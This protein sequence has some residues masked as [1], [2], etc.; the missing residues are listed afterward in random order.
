MSIHYNK[1]LDKIKIHQFKKNK[2]KI[3]K[4]KEIWEIKKMRE[5]RKIK[6]IW[7]VK[8]IKKIR[9]VKK[10]KKIMNMNLMM[11]C[12]VKMMMMGKM[13]IFLIKT[14]KL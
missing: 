6:K 4:I 7:E 9:E 14:F 2:N 10:I 13:K 12:L 1:N 8:K 5:I 11:I 3:K